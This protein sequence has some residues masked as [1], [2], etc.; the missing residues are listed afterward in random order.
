MKEIVRGVL[1][2]LVFVHGQGYMHRDVKPEN[3]MVVRG[4]FE[5][6]QLKK[7]GTDLG[8]VMVDFG[9]AQKEDDLEWGMYRCG[10][11]GYVAP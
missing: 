8:V 2:G 1:E 10:T 7:R 4:G 6:R 9:F 5:K 11:P 3:V